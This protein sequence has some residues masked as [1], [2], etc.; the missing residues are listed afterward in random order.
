MA[1]VYCLNQE[2]SE[3]IGVF[4]V[5]KDKMQGMRVPK[6]AIRWRVGSKLGTFK[7]FTR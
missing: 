2:R 5:P 3:K 7:H 1:R 4:G 6:R